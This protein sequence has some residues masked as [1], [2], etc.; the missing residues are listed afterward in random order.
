MKK[1][2]EILEGLLN[3]DNWAEEAKGGLKLN[4]YISSIKGGKTQT[5]H[6]YNMYAFKPEDFTFNDIEETIKEKITKKTSKK[7]VQEGH[8]YVDFAKTGMYLLDCRKIQ[9]ELY[10]KSARG[11]TA[12]ISKDKDQIRL[13]IGQSSGAL[14][15]ITPDSRGTVYEIPQ[16]IFDIILR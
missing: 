2:V 12:V 5:M 11:I 10:G 9:E 1:L 6:G 8:C 14:W 15:S 13:T 4:Y 7:R 16:E 3:N